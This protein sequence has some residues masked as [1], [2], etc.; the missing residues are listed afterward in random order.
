MLPALAE[1]SPIRK[2]AANFSDA[3][4]TGGGEPQVLLAA[5]ADAKAEELLAGY[6]EGLSGT[7][8][9]ALAAANA[10]RDKAPSTR[11]GAR[12]TCTTGSRRSISH[13]TGS[14]AR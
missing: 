13:R 1:R 12:P 6:A 8:A 2:P 4:S 11:R 5:S 10:N 3:D 14:S 7:D 9:S